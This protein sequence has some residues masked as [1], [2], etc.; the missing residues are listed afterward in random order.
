[1][2]FALALLMG[3][4]A[5]RVRPLF[6]VMAA[7]ALLVGYNLFA[8]A[9]FNG[10]RIVLEMVPQNLTV[11]LCFSGVLTLRLVTEERERRAMR[12]SMTRYLPPHIVE[13]L[14]AR[15]HDIKLGGERRE[16]TA[17][18]CDIRNFTSASEQ[19]SSGDTV[20]LLNRF[21]NAMDDVIWRHDGLLDNHMGDCLMAF[22][23]APHDQPDHAERAVQAA[24]EMSEWVDAMADEWA[25]LGYKGL[26][27]GIGI[28]T[29]E[30]TVG[31][32]GSDRRMHYTAVGDNVNIA[33]RL[34]EL[35]RECQVTILASEST[36]NAAANVAEFTEVGRVSIR[37]VGQDVTIYEV[38]RKPPS[39]SS[40]SGR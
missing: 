2:I 7:A 14:A 27:V 8:F 18:F 28:C 25:E 19:M 30:A 12:E 5:A 1:L 17:V 39:P 29:G 21:F 9:L 10:H 24:L 32:V 34:Q 13:D 26:Q 4:V 31:N 15:P 37:G 6:G 20:A 23:G 22:F 38:R 40:S 33:S 3:W 36:R 16:I 11:L 35:T